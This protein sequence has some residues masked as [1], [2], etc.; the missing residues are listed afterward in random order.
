MNGEYIFDVRQ[1]KSKTMRK[2]AESYPDNVRVYY[3]K[4]G[5]CREPVFDAFVEDFIIDCNILERAGDKLLSLDWYDSHIQKES[6][7]KLFDAN[8]FAIF[9]ENDCTD[10]LA[11]PDGG[12]IQVL[13]T[14]INKLIEV[15]VDK[16]VDAWFGTTPPSKS[17]RRRTA[18]EALGNAWT[19]F[20]EVHLSVPHRIGLR[21]G[22]IF[23]LNEDKK[24]QF[25]ATK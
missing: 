9:T 12:A 6:L 14:K 15:T 17:L 16:D 23:K 13:K 3:W 7:V 18:L 25:E 2:E 5:M 10:I 24:K 21:T 22:Q 4:S 11:M 8:I 19:W 20:R 1:A